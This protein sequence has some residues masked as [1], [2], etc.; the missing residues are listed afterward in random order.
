M[1][2]F[3]LTLLNII[4]YVSIVLCYYDLYALC[5][6]YIRPS[7]QAV[8][9]HSGNS[10]NPPPPPMMPPSTWVS[11]IGGQCYLLSCLSRR[12]ILFQERQMINNSF[13]L[14]LKLESD[15]ATLVVVEVVKDWCYYH[16]TEVLMKLRSSFVDV[17]LFHFS[18]NTIR[19]Y[20]QINV[21]SLE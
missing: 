14:C 11:N 1:D 4:V 8:Y 2:K 9:C 13:H 15:A 21:Q 7:I 18:F 3:K 6:L 16:E 5:A 17:Y 19:N 12:K 20:R 10:I